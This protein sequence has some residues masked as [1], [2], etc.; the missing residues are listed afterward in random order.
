MDSADRDAADLARA[1]IA[2]R[3]HDPARFRAAL[4]AVAP[5][6]RDAWLD[7]VL[8]LD[9]LP[10]DG[11]DLPRHCVPYLPCACDVLLRAIDGAAIAH[12]DVFVDVG[13]GL[14]R[15]A[16]V[17]HLLT[18]AA[19]IGLE[20]QRELA[21]ASRELAARLAAPIAIVDGDASA[22]AA[23]AAASG[24]VFFLYCPFGGDRLARLLD[25][26]ATLAAARELRVCCVD[27]PLPPRPWLARVPGPDGA[28]V[29]YRTVAHG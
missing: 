6:A 4:L 23:T 1:A 17:V 5:A 18:G 29:V 27:L 3:E 9:A 24:S 11:A 15:A 28:L 20:I 16:A 8:G 21:R 12:G 22:L 25:A 2:R 19:A 14:G 7:L 13:S 10:D 26:L